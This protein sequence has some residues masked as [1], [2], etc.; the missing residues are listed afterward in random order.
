MEK[1]PPMVGMR[2]RMTDADRDEYG[3]PEW[4]E[5]RESHLVDLPFDDIDAAEQAMGMSVAHLLQ[6]EMPRFTVRAIRA[7][8]WLALRHADVDTPWPQFKPAALRADVVPIYAD[9]GDADPPA[10]TGE[11]SATSPPGSS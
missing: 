6:V 8:L 5:F 3:G 11:P 10:P 4:V 9:S 1:A 7:V 2:L